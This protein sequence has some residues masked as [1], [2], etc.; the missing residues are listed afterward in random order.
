MI[1]FPTSKKVVNAV[2]SSRQN[3]VVSVPCPQLLRPNP[4]PRSL[5]ITSTSS[6]S[7]PQEAARWVTGLVIAA[8]IISHPAPALADQA[9]QTFVNNCGGCH[10]GGGN[11]VRREA[12]LKLEDLTK[13]GVDSVD[14]LYNVIYSGRGSM[15]GYG[16]GCT[17]K[18][19]CTFGRRLSE[20]DV[21]ELA[22]YVLKQAKAGW[23]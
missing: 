9:E 20:T 4:Y 15:P 3:S 13:Y 11:I 7:L 2:A 12:T 5:P 1:E 19:A 22:E 6:L 8:S 18:G 17:P 21:R 10:A 23:E 16:E 14:E